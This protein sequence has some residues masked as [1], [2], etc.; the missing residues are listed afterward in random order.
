MATR[1]QGVL[2][3]GKD[4][5][6]NITAHTSLRTGRTTYRVHYTCG[7]EKVLRHNDNWPM[8][9][10]RFFTADDTVRTDD[11]IIGN[12]ENGTRYELFV[13]AN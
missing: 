3:G 1:I 5:I 6:K 4:M 12:R 11:R 2:I 10:V 8:S 9:V 7:R 13:K